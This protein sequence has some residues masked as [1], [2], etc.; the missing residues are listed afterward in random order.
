MQP[1]LKEWLA[2]KPSGPAPKVP[3]KKRSAKRE[4]EAKEYTKLRK[5]YLT[6]RG[7]EARLF[8]CTGRMVEIHHSQGRGKNL[9]NVN[10]W[11]GVCRAC[12]IFIHSHPSKARELG[13]L[14]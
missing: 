11:V 3:V 7:C 8:V 9:N 1:T 5:A 13:L 12:H 14:K 2:R 6:R 4:R 10:T